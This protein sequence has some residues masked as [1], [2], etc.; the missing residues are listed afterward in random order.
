V[1]SASLPLHDELVKTLTEALMQL[2][3]RKG[4]VAD[5]CDIRR[6]VICWADYPP[7]QR[8]VGA[9]DAWVQWIVEPTGSHYRVV[10]G[11][12][13]SASIW[14]YLEGDAHGLGAQSRGQVLPFRASNHHPIEQL[15]KRYV[16]SFS[17]ANLANRRKAIDHAFAAESFA[18]VAAE[19]CNRMTH[20]LLE[21]KS[22]TTSLQSWLL[23]L[24]ADQE[25]F[26]KWTAH[27]QTDV[28]VLADDIVAATKADF[29]M[30]LFELNDRW[31]ED[32]S[33]C[34]SH[35]DLTTDLGILDLSDV[36]SLL[37]GSSEKPVGSIDA[38]TTA[39]DAY[40]RSLRQE[41]APHDESASASHQLAAESLAELLAR[42]TKPE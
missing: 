27:G 29:Q 22:S 26:C 8:P 39:I 17:R 37:K 3:Q 5:D 21:M 30:C 41:L 14:R 24:W 32:V 31:I 4:S 42:R 36:Y 10:E 23:P 33:N 35:D 7:R 15:V 25:T 9:H 18:F 34:D 38:A 12:C 2:A 16:S 11:S 28:C 13:R 19:T 20:Y 40:V 6:L 1:I